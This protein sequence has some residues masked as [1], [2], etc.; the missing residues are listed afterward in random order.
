MRGRKKQPDSF[1]ETICIKLTKEQ[2]E[3]WTKN[4]WIADEVR[5]TVRNHIN[6]YVIKR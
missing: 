2:K 3:I 4:K 6:I 5:A 1:S